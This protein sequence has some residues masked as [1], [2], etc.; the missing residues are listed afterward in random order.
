MATFGD[1]LRGKAQQERQFLTP[2]DARRLL[3][4]VKGDRLEAL[5][6][7]ALALGLR[8][9]E[10][11]GLRWKDINFSAGTLTVQVALHAIEGRLQLEEL[12]TLHSRRQLTLPT[13]ALEALRV[14][15]QRQEAERTALGE[16]WRET[17]GLVF[18]TARGTPLNTRNVTRSFHH[19]LDRAGLARMR[20][21]DMRHTC[22]SLLIALGVHPRVVM[23]IL[24]HSQISLTMNTYG[25]VM[26]AAHE[27]AAGRLNDLFENI[28]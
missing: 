7:V 10:A 18:T 12:K 27:D 16:Y 4:I 24:G 9:G 14:H 28:K 20:F 15:Q 21:Y 1:V 6:T 22:A 17:E 19:L 3:A 8:K 11:L 23:E 2:D 26:P 13:I 25:H 5:Y